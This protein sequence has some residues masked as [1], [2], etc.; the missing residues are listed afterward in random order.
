M[1]TEA[2]AFKTQSDSFHSQ[3]SR[4]CSGEKALFARLREKE[5]FQVS[6]R[7]SC[8]LQTLETAL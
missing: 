5:L 2:D 7:N 3:H 8:F 4:Q 1:Q 6:A